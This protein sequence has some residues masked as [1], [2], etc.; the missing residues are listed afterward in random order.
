MLSIASRGIEPQ[1]ALRALW[2]QL[3]ILMKDL[4]AL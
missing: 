3:W 2:V 4:E 1:D